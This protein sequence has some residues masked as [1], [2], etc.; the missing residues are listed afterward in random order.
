MLV[1]AGALPVLERDAELVIAGD[2]LSVHQGDDVTQL[3]GLRATFPDYARFATEPADARHLVVDRGE[4][5]EAVEEQP[6]GPLV[7]AFR[8]GVVRIGEDPTVDLPARYDGPDQRFVIEPAYLHDAASAAQT[9]D[10][11]LHIAGPLD[12]LFVRSTVDDRFLAVIMP[13]RVASPRRRR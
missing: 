3:P 8:S 13:V 7:V 9:S 1:A 12:P 5:V 10:V 6:D 2:S 4:L 11:S